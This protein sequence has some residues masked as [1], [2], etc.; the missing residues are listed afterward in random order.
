MQFHSKCE[1]IRPELPRDL[2]ITM[3]VRDFCK[4]AATYGLA[5]VLLQAAGLILLPV[6]TRCLTEADYG[7]LEIL[8]RIAETV[9]TFLFIGGLRQALLTFYQQSSDPGDR[10]RVVS[11]T[12]ALLL[13][14]C[15]LGGSVVLVGAH[16]LCQWLSGPEQPIGPGLFGLAVLGILLEPFTLIPLALMQSRVE[17]K[18]FVL[19]TLAQLLLRITLT[20]VFLTWLDWGVHGVLLATALTTGLFGITLSLREWLTA[21]T[22]PDWRQSLALLRFALPFLPGG[23]CFFV[24]HHGD[25]FFLLKWWGEE[26]V[27]TYALGYKLA[28]VVTTFSLNPLYMVWSVRLYEVARTPAAPKAFGEV[29]TRILAAYLLFG[30]A[31]GLFQD[32]VIILLGGGHFTG[33]SAVVAPVLLACFFQTGSSLMDSAFYVRRRTGLKLGITLASTVIMLVLYCTLIPRWRGPGAALAT[34]LGFGFHAAC[35]LCVTQRLFPVRYEWGRLMAMLFLA[36]ALWAISRFLPAALWAWPIKA[37]LWGLWPLLIWHTGLIS[38]M[39]KQYAATLIR[40]ATQSLVRSISG[41]LDSRRGTRWAAL[42][43]MDNEGNNAPP[44]ATWEEEA[45]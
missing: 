2:L 20:V 33:A 28:M 25:R 32:D 3:N 35:T 27:G 31:M 21:A 38:I 4:H 8:G 36:G 15:T 40:Q 29:F 5:T 42:L 19:I 13:L 23:I 44:G 11:S 24:L 7:V 9:G 16:P 34:L 30:L 22:W 41:I 17:S 39:E 12:L 43:V 18:T 1:S 45:A 37:G 26:E 6:Y 10:E 14:F